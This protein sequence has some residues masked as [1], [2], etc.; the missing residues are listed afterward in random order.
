MSPS[1]SPRPSSRS[2]PSVTRCIALGLVWLSVAAAVVGF[3]L[4]WVVLR[5]PS[6][7]VAGQLTDALQGTP[8]GALTERLNRKVGHV[9]IEIRRGAETVVGTLP[10]LST[11]PTHVSGFEIPR[12]LKRQ[13][14]Q[15]LLALT[16]TLTPYRGLG[17]KTLAVYLV[18][19]LAVVCGLLVTLARRVRLVCLLTGAVCCSVAAGGLWKLSTTKIGSSVVTVVFGPGLWLS[20]WAYAVL[21]G[22]ALVLAWVTVRRASS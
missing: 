10:D 11:I 8:L 1:V 18:P 20:L 3:F 19:V 6:H 9:V 21:G 16:E 7:S 15:G 4:P 12:L 22:A 17:V 5:A 2:V 13:D 14:L